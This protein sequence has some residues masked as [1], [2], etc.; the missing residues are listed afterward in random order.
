[1]E[2]LVK[3][4]DSGTLI[5]YNFGKERM[6]FLTIYKPLEFS[7]TLRYYLAI[8]A[9]TKLPPESEY[10]LQSLLKGYDGEKD[11]ASH[12]NELP[13][14]IPILYDLLFEVSQSTIQI[15]ALCILQ[16]KLILFEIKNFQGNFSAD[17]EKWYSPSNKE[18]KNPLNQIKRA[19]PL[20]HQFLKK[21]QLHIPFDY[22]LIFV[23]PT[24]VL[25]GAT[26]H[27][28][29]IFPGQ[30][31]EFMDNLKQQTFAPQRMH[32][33][34]IDTF[35]SHHKSDLHL[36]HKPVYHYD[37]MTKGL[38]CGQCGGKMKRK[39]KR[40]FSCMQCHHSATVNDIVLS[41]IKDYMTLFPER[42]V[43][44]ANIYDWI[45][46]EVS[47]NAIIKI[48]HNHFERKGVGKSIHYIE[49]K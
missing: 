39:H 19:E 2:L 47:P 14:D 15:D 21:H 35:L 26:H 44:T 12:L 32:T 18:I 7:K 4:N 33:K 42:K 40:T 16:H 45:G 43:T 46:G 41:N 6:M 3:K 23:H 22:Y 34:I 17:D 25:Y 38:F 28:H 29:V 37:Q 8:Y 11:W 31:P 49:F 1:M 48:L 13:D 27:E 36:L 24:F 5:G 30:I 10:Y 9:R 20:L